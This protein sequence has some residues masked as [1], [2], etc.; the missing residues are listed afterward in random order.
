MAVLAGINSAAVLRLK[1]TRE[2][3][4]QRNKKLVGQFTELES[5]MSSER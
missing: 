3:V 2:S 5:L 4:R 1:I